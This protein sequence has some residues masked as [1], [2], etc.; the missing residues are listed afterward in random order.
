MTVP[1]VTRPAPFRTDVIDIKAVCTIE[2]P[3]QLTVL[4]RCDRWMG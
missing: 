4:G 2:N 1:A 3:W